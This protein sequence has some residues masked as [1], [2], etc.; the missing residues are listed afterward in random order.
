[1]EHNSPANTWWE[2]LVGA[3]TTADIVGRDRGNELKREDKKRRAQAHV[4]LLIYFFPGAD[5]LSRLTD[6]IRMQ[7][8]GPVLVLAQYPRTMAMP[9]LVFADCATRHLVWKKLAPEKRPQMVIP[10]PMLV[11]AHAREEIRIPWSQ[12]TPGQAADYFARVQHYLLFSVRVTVMRNVLSRVCYWQGKEGSE[13]IF[14]KI[15]GA[16]G[17]LRVIQELWAADIVADRRKFKICAR[18]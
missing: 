18:Y 17:T 13:V 11:C 3:A 12:K 1:M 4:Y 14:K 16:G 2:P 15:F 10:I 9:G 5:L 8:R 6:F 7:I